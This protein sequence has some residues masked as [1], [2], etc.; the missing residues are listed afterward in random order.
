MLHPAPGIFGCRVRV[1]I[2]ALTLEC[3]TKRSASPGHRALLPIVLTPT[4][5]ILQAPTVL[6]LQAVTVH[7]PT[8]LTPP[9]LTVPTATVLRDIVLVQ[10]IW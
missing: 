7:I 9:A 10:A 4:P 2:K 6:T 5:L 8:P 1:I 3:R